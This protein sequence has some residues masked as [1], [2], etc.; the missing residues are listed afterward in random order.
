M[1]KNLFSGAILLIAFALL[2]GAIIPASAAGLTL[3]TVAATKSGKVKLTFEVDGAPPASTS[4]FVYS[5]YAT[6]PMHCR[7][8]EN[9]GILVCVIF[10][11][12]TKYAG[13]SAWFTLGGQDFSITI[14]EK[15]LQEK[16]ICNSSVANFISRVD[17]SQDAPWFYFG[18]TDFS[19]T[20]FCV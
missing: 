7:F 12:I 5:G 20:G 17:I 8:N 18:Q 19:N 16:N 6:Y 13:N 14:P 9:Q 11:N 3:S 4:T 2:F 15:P 1:K 10:G